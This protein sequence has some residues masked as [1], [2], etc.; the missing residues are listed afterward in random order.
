[1][2]L[3]V[4]SPR[5]Y[6]LASDD[7]NG[8]L[9]RQWRSDDGGLTFQSEQP[10][11]WEYRR[12]SSSAVLL[13]AVWAIGGAA[14][15]GSRA[16]NDVWVAPS[17]ESWR[18]LLAAAA[19]PARSR[20]VLVSSPGQLWILGG[21]DQSGALMNDVWIAYA[22]SDDS[23]LLPS[24]VRDLG[25]VLSG[26]GLLATGVSSAAAFAAGVAGNKALIASSFPLSMLSNMQV[27]DGVF[28]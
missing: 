24:T 7:G 13:D 18:R 9:A 20:H 16:T 12:H 2:S 3:L 28:L 25:V 6:V 8:G 19:F 1:M 10:P 15:N 5:L 26:I 11:S 4:V 23:N 17:D 21:E 27:L 22:S 14:D